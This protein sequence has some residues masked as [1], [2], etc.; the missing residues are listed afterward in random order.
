MKINNLRLMGYPIYRTNCKCYR[1]YMMALL[2]WD[3]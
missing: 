3:H 1:S 2:P